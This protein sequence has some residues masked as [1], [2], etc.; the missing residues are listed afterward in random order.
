MPDISLL[1][2]A[3]L[4]EWRRLSMKFLLQITLLVCNYIWSLYFIESRPNAKIIS[5]FQKMLYI[6]AISKKKG[7]KTNSRVHVFIYLDIP[8]ELWLLLYK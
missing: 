1:V 2:L 3:S 5:R 4:L 6:L 8:L 7:L